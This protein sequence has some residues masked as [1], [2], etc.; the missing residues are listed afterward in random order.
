M[1]ECYYMMG[2]V[3]GR[4]GDAPTAIRLLEKS[5]SLVKRGNRLEV[6]VVDLFTVLYDNYVGLSPPDHNGGMRALEQLLALYPRDLKQLFNYYHLKQYISSLKRLVPLKREAIRAFD[7]QFDKYAKIA[8][9]GVIPPLQ[10]IR[11]SVFASMQEQSKVNMLYAKYVKG[12]DAFEYKHA[13]VKGTERIV[14]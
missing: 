5:A 1:S 3:Y 13:P 4:M 6:N 7:N 10:P 2:S 11:A 8:E 9:G 12:K 14:R